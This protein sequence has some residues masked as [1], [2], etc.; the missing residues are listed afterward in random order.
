V[1]VLLR[2]DLPGFVEFSAARTALGVEA[3]CRVGV[4]GQLARDAG[5]ALALLL[6]RRRLGVRL[7]P[8]RRRHR[9]IVRRL[10]RSA[11]IGFEFS[12]AGV[13]SL[14]LR[15]Q[16]VDALIPGG[17]LRHKLVDPRHKRRHQIGVSSARRI[18][19]A[20]PHGERESSRRSR[21]NNSDPSHNAAEG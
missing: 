11:E 17:D 7:L 8:A 2:E 16:F 18:V 20:L 6:G 19:L 3:S 13:L 5:P 15:Q 12:D 21:L 1:I 4:L 10:R 14:H 9:G